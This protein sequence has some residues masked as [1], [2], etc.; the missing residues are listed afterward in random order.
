MDSSGAFKHR[1][2]IF[3]LERKNKLAAIC[4]NNVCVAAGCLV[5]SGFSSDEVSLRAAAFVDRVLTGEKPADLPVEQLTKSHFSVNL[6]TVSALGIT[7]P[8]SVLVR[9]D[10]V[11]E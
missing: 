7:I 5:C 3:E 2:A 1:H 6:K 9:A 4:D 8:K 10:Q 11:I